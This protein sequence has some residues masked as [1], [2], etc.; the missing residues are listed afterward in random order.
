MKTIFKIYI[1]VVRHCAWQILSSLGAELLVAMLGPI[2]LQVYE[3]QVQALEAGAL[4][5]LVLFLIIMLTV[6]I[7]AIII[8]NLDGLLTQ[9]MQ[10]EITRNFGKP[11][12]EY[13]QNV[14]LY[15]MSDS[16][17]V[18]D[19]ERAINA[20]ENDIL[21]VVQNI[22][23][24][25]ALIVSIIVLSVMVAQYDVLALVVLIIMVIV[26][27]VFTKRGTSEGVE[28]NKS[29]EMFKIKEAYFNKLF[30]DKNSSKEIR[31]WRLTD[32]IEGKRYW[33][34]EEIKRKTLDLEKKWTG[35]NLF[36]ACVMYFFEFIY[37]IVLYIRYTRGS[38][39]LGTLIYLIQ[40]LST[41]LVSF[42]QVIQH[43][44]IIASIKYE[45]D[46]YFEFAEKTN[47]K[48]N[49][50]KSRKNK[51]KKIIFE[52]V[53]FEYKKRRLLQ[54]ISF[55]IN[56]GEKILIVGENG[57]GKST[58]LNLILGLLQP[59]RGKVDIGANK[60]ALMAQES[61]KF[62]ITIRENIIFS[63]EKNRDSLILNT[64][65]KLT[66]LSIVGRLENGLDTRIGA[67]LYDDGIDLSGGE[68]QKIV[69]TRTLLDNADIWIFDEPVAAMDTEVVN[70][71]SLGI[72]VKLGIIMFASYIVVQV[73][74]ECVSYFQIYLNTVLQL[75]LGQSVS[76]EIN[77]KLAKVKLNSLEMYEIH[78]L[79]S[80][81]NQ[82]I[83]SS[84]VSSLN[85][86]I[87]LYTP[88]ATI[89]LQ[90]ASLVWVA[91]YVPILIAVFNVPYIFILVKSNHR[92]YELERK[93]TKE[94]R[95]EKYFV[96]LL[97]D[98]Y[99]AKDIRTYDLVNFFFSKM[100]DVK[101]KITLEYKR[102]CQKNTFQRTIATVTQ[103]MA[104]A[105]A[106]L[107]TG[108]LVI[109]KKT[110]IGAF[111]LV[112][113]TGRNLQSAVSSFVGTIS[114][115]DQFGIN[116]ADWNRLM[117]LEEEPEGDEDC[118]DK[119][120]EIEMKNV[121]F[122]YPQR[123]ES[124]VKN[125]NLRILT[126]E[127]IA[128]VGE[129]GSGKTTLLYLLLGI[130]R[131]ISGEA[132]VNG[133]TM[134][135]NLDN[136]RKK[137][138]CLI[139]NFVHFQMTLRENL[140]PNDFSELSEDPLIDFANNFPDRLNTFLGALDSNGVEL[141]GGQWKRIALYRTLHKKDVD[142]I[143]LDEP[144]ANLD[145]KI[146]EN[147]I[148]RLL[149]PNYNKTVIVIT[150]DFELAKKFDRI[151]GMK[152]GKIICDS[153]P[154]AFAWELFEKHNSDKRSLPQIG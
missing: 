42:T 3:K 138:A 90:L 78:D 51:S 59:T 38:V 1:M 48:P 80:R 82:T 151:I 23:G 112:Y 5:Q 124:A 25:I 13:I 68:T 17:F 14:P 120:H 47:G 91:W 88:L 57:S 45:I 123:S 10:L 136:Y 106:L 84:I 70:K 73:I 140:A 131:P 19:K 15:H 132:S 6:N 109:K 135:L 154:Q 9:K 76:H 94:K 43:I 119:I 146:S 30:V 101:E 133:K 39:M 113:N 139:Q 96:E 128:I 75:K 114:T 49:I 121:E 63:K 127:K 141:S 36:W 55:S 67:S 22:N 60:I 64:M 21:L 40:V 46:T 153:P 118:I 129:N 7:V 147:I 152:E 102:L 54:E 52:N 71:L 99:A 92:R 29:L 126:G 32:Y 83:K 148:N 18:A 86:I 79:V 143:V 69:A 89:V 105:M 145:P 95:V 56:P 144:T 12:F 26:Q 20:V 115:W 122:R 28:L 134:E 8:E 110:P 58:L 81:A 35:I 37:Y 65:Q 11:V 87:A 130:Y 4:E 104:M 74:E 98:R 77:N 108:Y 66:A 62:N 2:G 150:H 44:K 31:Q 137:T 97:S 93:I 116:F 16:N 72:T 24:S 107:L 41:Y 27:N 149:K 100:I 103:S 34:N 61:Y 125:I 117:N 53:D 85:L 50:A 33:L 111:V 142:L